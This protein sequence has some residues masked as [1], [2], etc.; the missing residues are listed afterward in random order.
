MKAGLFG[1][2]VVMESKQVARF[3]DRDCIRLQ[4]VCQDCMIIF[5]TDVCEL[6]HYNEYGG[7]LS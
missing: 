3:I 6:F 1:Q 2:V 4:E 5:V 7:G